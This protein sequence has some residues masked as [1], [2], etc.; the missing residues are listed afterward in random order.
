MCIHFYRI[1]IELIICISFNI[2]YFCICMLIPE[3]ICKTSAKT[4]SFT[5]KKPCESEVFR[6]KSSLLQ[7]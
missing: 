1:V 3:K 4:C 6:D 7:L 2:V 5:C